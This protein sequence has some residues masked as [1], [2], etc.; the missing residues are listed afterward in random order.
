MVH[1]INSDGVETNGG[2]QTTVDAKIGMFNVPS[3]LNTSGMRTHVDVVAELFGVSLKNPEDI[4]DFTKGIELGKYEVWLE[5]TSDKHKDVMDTIYAMYDAFV[6]ENP[7]VTSSYSSNSVKIDSLESM[8][9]GNT[10]LDDTVHVDDPIVQ[11]QSNRVISVLKDGGGEFDDGLDEINLGLSE[12]FVIKVLDDRDIFDESLVVF[13][14]FHLGR[15]PMWYI[16]L[17]CRQGC[18]LKEYEIPELR[19]LLDDTLRARWFR[20]SEECYALIFAHA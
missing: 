20:R 9:K 7:N 2:Y 10:N 6:A 5:L 12:E 14:E 19:F 3:N 4:D 16:L 17:F 8:A 1:E 13:F 18:W 11:A 15:N